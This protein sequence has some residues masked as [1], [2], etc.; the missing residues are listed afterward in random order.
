MKTLL[1]NPPL[2][3]YKK[4]FTKYELSEPLGLLY[5]A[6]YLVQHEKEVKILDCLG[7][8]RDHVEQD[9]DHF[10]HGLG[11]NAIYDYIK[12]YNPDIIGISSMFTLH[13]KGVK[14]VAEVA[15]KAC[16]KALIV[17]GGSNASALSEI[18]MED[19]NVD[20]VVKGEGELTLLDIIE[21]LEAGR[22]LLDIPGTVVRENAQIKINPPR[23]FIKDLDSLPFP[24]RDMIPIDVYLHDWYR[25]KMAMRPPRANMI[26]SRGCAFNC[27]FCATHA[28]WR[29]VWRPRSAKNVVDEIEY[30]VK[31][32][33]VR[34]VAFQDDNLTLKK[35]RMI[36]ICDE[37]INR[38]LNIKWCTP[39]GVAIWTL[40]EE[41]L[42]KM[43][44]SGC[45]R[46]TFGI[47][48]GSLE[49]Q[50]FI[51]KTQINL[52]KAKKII[53]YCNKIGIW[54][55]SAFIIGF[56]YET[57]NNIEDTVNYAI[58]SDLDGAAFFIATPLPSTDMFELYKNEGLITNL[59]HDITNW[60]ATTDTAAYDTKYLKREE[61]QTMKDGAVSRFYRRS[62]MRFLNP[63]R[64]MRKVHSI[65]DFKYAL[66]LAS[67]AKEMI[68]R[69]KGKTTSISTGP[70]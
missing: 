27:I 38:N 2:S 36:E 16:P 48:T 43:K 63:L 12:N 37:I 34:E 25:T 6:A 55:H 66:H 68:N 50:K 64:I 7:L 69:V 30:L 22:E 70:I 47:E 21:R 61:I 23:E 65:E 40:D 33:G 52:E 67:I 49:T 13:Y 41:V 26:S 46:L 19:S 51:R 56:P 20:I 60:A 9:G 15:R 17:V 14:D 4:Q 62:A 42:D 45:Y 53:K 18:V 10:R 35:D 29:H 59:G 8:D 32:Y 28:I 1:I 44:K 54:T 24:A 3:I 39:N 57:K 11:L 5:I 58:N 31:T